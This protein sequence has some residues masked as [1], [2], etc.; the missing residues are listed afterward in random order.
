[1]SKMGKFDFHLG[2]IVINFEVN[3]SLQKPTVDSQ[4]FWIGELAEALEEILEEILLHDPLEI[5][6]N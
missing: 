5:A 6:C 1:M 2:D 4:T 3:K